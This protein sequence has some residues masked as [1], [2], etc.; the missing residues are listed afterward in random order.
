MLGA[1]NS[2]YSPAHGICPG[3][4]AFAL[5][6]ILGI[7]GCALRLHGGKGRVVGNRAGRHVANILGDGL[8]ERFGREMIVHNR[9]RQ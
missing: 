5:G 8:A 9:G 6:A 4:D 1:K 2:S 3:L 7:H